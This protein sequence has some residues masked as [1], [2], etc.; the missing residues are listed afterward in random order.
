VIIRSRER[1]REDLPAP[2]IA[3][4]EKCDESALRVA[5]KVR[6]E[7]KPE[8]ALRIAVRLRLSFSAETAPTS[9]KMDAF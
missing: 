8:K 5:T 2:A 3:D 1:G 7:E 9:T 6:C 4:E